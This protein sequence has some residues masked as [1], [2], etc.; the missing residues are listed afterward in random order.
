MS[1]TNAAPIQSD[2]T[3]PDGSGIL[4]LNRDLF[5]GVRLRQALSAEGWIP[6]LVPSAEAVAHALRTEAS[7][8]LIVVDMAA[9]PDWSIIED[10]AAATTPPTPILAFGPHKDVDAFRAAKAGGAARV[11]SNGDFHK[12]MTGFVRRYARHS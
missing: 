6:S 7:P 1:D 12:D 4:I 11:V 5:F 8:A 9:R 10:A 3:I 2:P